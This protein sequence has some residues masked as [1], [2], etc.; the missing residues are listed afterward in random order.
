VILLDEMVLPGSNVHW[1]VTQHD[2]TMM[3]SLAARERTRSE[4]GVLLGSVGLVIDEVWT[5]TPSVYESVIVVKR[6]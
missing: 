1:E 5:Y 3:A 2:L 4:W 6:K